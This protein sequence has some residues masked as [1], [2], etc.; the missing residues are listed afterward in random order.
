VGLAVLSHQ[1]EVAMLLWQPSTQVSS[2][3][4][5]NHGADYQVDIINTALMSTEL[6]LEPYYDFL[7][8]DIINTIWVYMSKIQELHPNEVS[9]LQATTPTTEEDSQGSLNIDVDVDRQMMIHVSQPGQCSLTG[10]RCS[11]RQPLYKAVVPQFCKVASQIVERRLYLAREPQFIEK[12]L[13]TWVRMVSF[14]TEASCVRHF[15]HRS[16]GY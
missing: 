1:L 3:D 2:L 4:N 10:Y 12:L 5:Q 14:V 9:R 15:Q 13:K 11:F 8:E 7:I 6:Y 16:P